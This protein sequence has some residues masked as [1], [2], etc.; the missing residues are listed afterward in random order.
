MKPDWKDAPG[1]ANWLAMDDDG[2][3]SWS[4]KKPSWDEEEGCWWTTKYWEYVSFDPDETDIYN[5]SSI[6]S[7]EPRPG[8]LEKFM[9]LARWVAN[10][11][12]HG[13]NDSQR[14]LGVELIELIYRKRQERDEGP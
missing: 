5:F 10:C 12:G 2:R 1:W 3:W 13:V 8:E 11:T 4:A 6:A 14:L 9:P 7:L